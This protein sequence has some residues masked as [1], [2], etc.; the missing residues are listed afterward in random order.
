MYRGDFG[1]VKKDNTTHNVTR[2]EEGVSESMMKIPK[3]MSTQHPDNVA[4]F[5][6]D[7]A[8]VEGDTE[9]DEAY[10]SYSHLGIDEQMWDYEGKEVDPHVVEK[11]SLRT[12]PS[13]VNAN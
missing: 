10:Y 12:K 3:C 8:I 6:F 5:F 7:R 9:I 13:F 2:A 11:F 1:T 4:P